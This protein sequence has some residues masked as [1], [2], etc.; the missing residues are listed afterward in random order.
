M[1]YLIFA[2]LKL[3]IILKGET[4]LKI[5]RNVNGKQMVFELTIQELGE[6]HEAYHDHWD[7]EYVRK[8]FQEDEHDQFCKVLDLP[9]KEKED[10]FEAIALRM[11][12]LLDDDDCNYDSDEAF[13][14][15]FDEF[16]EDNGYED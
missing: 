14:Q 6:A 4:K 7:L 13:Y 3:T 5:V 10:A 8:K 15:A 2:Y 11:R 9:E 1:S 12:E 16:L